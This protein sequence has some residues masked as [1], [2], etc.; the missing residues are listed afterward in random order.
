MASPSEVENR[1]LDAYA[2][3]RREVS[4]QSPPAQLLGKTVTTPL[5]SF[6]F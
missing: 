6:T 1:A 3:G 4:Y 5:W 2:P